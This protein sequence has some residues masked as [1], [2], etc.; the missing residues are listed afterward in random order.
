MS[1]TLAD[2]YYLKALD[3]Y[4][5][6]LDRVIEALNY[7][8]G[9]N[10]EHAGAHCLL[11]MLNMYQLGRYREAENHFEKALSSDLNYTETYYSYINLLIQTGEYGK[12]NKLIKYAY[13]IK[14]I[15]I[16]RLKYYEGL[17]AEVTGDYLKAKEY[18]KFAYGSSFRK[19]EREF[20]KEELDRVISKLKTLKKSSSK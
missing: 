1:I 2:T 16:S 4:P 5:Y 17:I 18:M 8:I 12:A 14:G 13:K 19:A 15:N 7:A 3:L 11:G 6:E 9:Y 20:L 10:N